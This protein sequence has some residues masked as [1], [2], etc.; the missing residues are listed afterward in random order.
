MGCL[1]R[2]YV[3]S[4]GQ[5]FYVQVDEDVSCKFTVVLKLLDVQDVQLKMK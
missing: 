2:I 3:A 4:G 5:L 1:C